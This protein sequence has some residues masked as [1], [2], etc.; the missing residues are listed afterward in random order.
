MLSWVTV[1]VSEA[2]GGEGGEG[3]GINLNQ[4]LIL[5]GSPSG[6]GV[7]IAVRQ[8]D[9]PRVRLALVASL[10]SPLSDVNLMNISAQLNS[11][12]NNRP[13]CPKLCKL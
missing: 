13:A 10:L 12:H 2:R 9:S 11:L 7:N 6:P 4:E 1:D 3:R 8:I 5:A